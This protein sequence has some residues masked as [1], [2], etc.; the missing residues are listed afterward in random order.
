MFLNEKRMPKQRNS[1]TLSTPFVICFA[2]FHGFSIF[3]L[4]QSQ[5]FWR[6]V[7]FDS[8][9][10]SYSPLGS[11]LQDRWPIGSQ[12]EIRVCYCLY[13]GVLRGQINL[14]MT[15]E[16]LST[17]HF[18]GHELQSLRLLG[19]VACLLHGSPTF[20]GWVIY[21]GIIYMLTGSLGLVSIVL[22]TRNRF[23]SW[24]K[25]HKQGTHCINLLL[26]TT[27]FSKH[28]VLDLGLVRRWWAARWIGNRRH[29]LSSNETSMVSC[30]LLFDSLLDFF[31]DS[32][33][34]YTFL[35]ASCLC[36]LLI[37]SKSHYSMTKIC[38]QRLEITSGYG[39]LKA[40]KYLLEPLL[41]I[42]AKSV[43]T[44]G[45][46]S[47]DQHHNVLLIVEFC[48]PLTSFDWNDTDPSLI[49]TCSIDTTCTIWDITTQQPKV[50]IWI[51]KIV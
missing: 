39:T 33:L 23:V 3:F 42:S 45:V 47:H 38:L 2:I 13:F 27:G 6:K 11:L 22:Y 10:I 8:H 19:T 25:L 1:P 20:I 21:G 35:F 49:V 12:L 26:W 4:A 51:T 16:N 34:C 9:W 28:I 18:E 37:A 46:V 5:G 29:V 41:P 36:F 48:A 50:S 17:S 15:I 30:T 32:D 24:R 44:N 31:V 43:K 14:E 7:P 40:L